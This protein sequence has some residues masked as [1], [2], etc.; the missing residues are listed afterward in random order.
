M[1]C[2]SSFQSIFFFKCNVSMYAS[3]LRC[4]AFFSTNGCFHIT[5]IFLSVSTTKSTRRKILSAEENLSIRGFKIN[6]SKVKEFCLPLKHKIIR[7][8][9]PLQ[10]LPESN[11]SELFSFITAHRMNIAKNVLIFMYWERRTERDCL[12][13]KKLKYHS[14]NYV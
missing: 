9:L 12:Y 13:K 14:L 8:L 5:I 3:A 10:Y 2:D 11:D 4:F 6:S 7:H 1:K